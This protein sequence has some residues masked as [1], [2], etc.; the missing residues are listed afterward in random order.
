MLGWRL[1]RSRVRPHPRPFSRGEKGAGFR[2]ERADDCGW[3]IAFDKFCSSFDKSDSFSFNNILLP[4]PMG[5]GAGGEGVTLRGGRPACHWQL[6]DK[7]IPSLATTS[8]C[9]RLGARAWAPVAIFSPWLRQGS[10]AIPGG[11]VPRGAPPPA[12]PGAEL[13]KSHRYERTGA[14]H[15]P[16]ATY[17]N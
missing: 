17:P 1:A 16:A 4:S 2:V 13:G 10:V 6:D 14:S 7:D 5:R 8:A 3:A 9:S 12:E 11:V 15:R